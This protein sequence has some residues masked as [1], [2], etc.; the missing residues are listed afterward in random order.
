MDI[1]ICAINTETFELQFAGAYNPL[2]LIRKNELTIYKG[3]RMPIG[4][5]RKE[6]ETFTNN[7]ITIERGDKINLFSDGF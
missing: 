7:I 5:Y 2:Y 3:D 1:S 6:K 4:I